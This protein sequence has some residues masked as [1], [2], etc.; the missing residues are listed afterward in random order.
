MTCVEGSQA[1]STELTSSQKNPTHDLGLR[2]PRSIKYPLFLHIQ[3]PFP[4]Y[5]L[6]IPQFS[7][8]KPLWAHIVWVVVWPWPGQSALRK[9]LALEWVQR[10]VHDPRKSSEIQSCHF[11]WTN[12]EREASF[13]SPAI[14]MTYIWIVTGHYWRGSQRKRPT[15]KEARNGERPSPNVFIWVL[16]LAIPEAVPPRYCS[17][18][19]QSLSLGMPV[20]S[21]VSVTCKQKICSCYTVSL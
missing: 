17:F 3:Q 11:C 2:T 4:I 7:F 18:A 20:L 13:S 9:L 21:W 10:Q 12:W 14:Q 6:T 8:E 16:D 5:L 1:H 15:G 19:S